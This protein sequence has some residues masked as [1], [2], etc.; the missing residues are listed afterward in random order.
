MEVESPRVV[1][2]DSLNAYLYD[3]GSSLPFYQANFHSTMKALSSFLRS[4]KAS[5]VLVSPGM[6]LHPCSLCLETVRK[7]SGMFYFP[8]NAWGC[9][10]HHRLYCK[11]I[12]EPPTE[13]MKEVSQFSISEV[14]NG[15]NHCR[16][17]ISAVD[18]Y[19][20]EDAMEDQEVV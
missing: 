1:L 3:I 5:L 8:S 7:T 12:H 2:V 6:K 9:H 10:I 14:G 18:M 15:S 19:F 13:D 4:K 11:P 20:A 17:C 16:F